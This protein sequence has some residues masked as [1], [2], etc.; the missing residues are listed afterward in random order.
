[1]ILQKLDSD[2]VYRVKTDAFL[3]IWIG[4]GYCAAQNTFLFHNIRE[5]LKYYIAFSLYKSCTN[6]RE[7]LARIFTIDQAVF[8]V[9]AK[10]SYSLKQSYTHRLNHK[11][12]KINHNQH[13]ALRLHLRKLTL[14]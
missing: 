7:I 2:V 11:K 8:Q 10:P 6:L 13:N 9:L 3:K 14:C 4:M 1:M 5:T 12:Y